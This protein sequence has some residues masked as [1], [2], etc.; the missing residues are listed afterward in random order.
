LVVRYIL[1]A[2]GLVTAGV[3][4]AAMLW[5]RPDA[6]SASPV[7][8]PSAT[9]GRHWP[10]RSY[11]KPWSCFHGPNYGV[12]PW[13]N[14]PV[15]PSP[16]WWDGRVY[17]AN[18]NSCL[19]CYKTSD[20]AKELWQ[21]RGK[22]PDVA[23]PVIVNGLI[24]LGTSSGHLVCV[25]AT[26]GKEVWTHKTPRPYA[27]LV[28]SGDRVYSLG[29]DGTMHI[30][31]AEHTYRLLGT[32]PLGEGADATPA[33]GDGRIYIRGRSNLWCFETP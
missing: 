17:F 33:L 25:D 22:L 31:A 5:P 27:S 2:I 18:V 14:V 1:L 32:C 24:F 29:R 3:V 10:T 21:V 28:A 20:T 9:D 8:V 16:V 26:T 19:I 6:M 15:A 23:S 11:D 7:L 4:A 13:T 30:V 12:S